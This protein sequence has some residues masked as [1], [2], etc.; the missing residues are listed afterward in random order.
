MTDPAGFSRASRSW[1]PPKVS[2]HQKRLQSV[3]RLFERVP[4]SITHFQ[5]RKQSIVVPH[6]V[7]EVSTHISIENFFHMGHDPFCHF[8]FAVGIGQ[9]LPI[10]DSN[11]LPGAIVGPDNK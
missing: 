5:W 3:A 2:W 10:D 4:H 9:K 8:H 7:V 6:S 11:R 1:F